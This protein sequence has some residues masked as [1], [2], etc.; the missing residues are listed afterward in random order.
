MESKTPH[1]AGGTGQTTGTDT[2]QPIPGQSGKRQ[3]GN[4]HN[5]SQRGK[6]TQSGNGTN[7]FRGDTD[8][9][10]G[11]VFEVPPRNSQ[12]SD[13]LD[14]LKRYVRF[15]YKSA[16]IMCSLFAIKPTKPAVQKPAASAIPTGAP[17]TK[18]GAAVLTDFDRE[19]YREQVKSYRQE[20]LDLNRNAHGLAVLGHFWAMQPTVARPA[21][22]PK[23]VP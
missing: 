4:S 15:T 1:E 11:Y 18:G 3:H 8:K 12:L 13:T 10:R 2:G 5:P 23:G 20:L 14:M 16:P 6:P 9:M 7:G 19:I 22:V 17:A 21:P